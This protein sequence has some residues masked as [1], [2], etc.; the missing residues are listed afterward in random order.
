[1]SAGSG[2]GLNSALGLPAA[3]ERPI[4]TAAEDKLERGTFIR[5]LSDSLV[6]PATKKSTGVIVCVTGPWGSGKSSVLNLLTNQLGSAYP[7]IV[8]RALRSL[9]DFGAQRFDHEFIAELIAELH[10]TAGR[11][12]SRRQS[13]SS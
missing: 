12:S 2:E 6:A 3:L 10:Q 4:Q 11:S 1:M 7:E 5:R 8:V 13:A 9:A